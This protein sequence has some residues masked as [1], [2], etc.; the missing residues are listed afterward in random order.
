M[1]LL[2]DYL[3]LQ[4]QIYEYFGFVENWKVLPIQ[5]SRQYHW[6][7]NERY[8]CVCYADTTEE[9][10]LQTGNYYEDYFCYF[11]DKPKA[12]HEAKDYTLITVDTQT[13]GNKFMSIFDNTKRHRE[14]D[15]LEPI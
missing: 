12:V 13:D 4:K 15:N 14:L 10:A 9:L 11:G 7:M 5:D 3:A 1:K 2:D 6:F 8:G